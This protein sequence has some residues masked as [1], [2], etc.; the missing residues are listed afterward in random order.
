[1]KKLGLFC[2][3][4]SPIACSKQ[5]N[6]QTTLLKSPIFQNLKMLTMKKLGFV[7]L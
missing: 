3:V 7:A 5:I 6:R 1:M 2:L 4:V